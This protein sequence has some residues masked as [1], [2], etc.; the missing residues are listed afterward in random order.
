MKR[1][2]LFSLTVLFF[3]LMGYS[4][5]TWMDIGTYSVDNGPACLT[6]NPPGDFTHLTDVPAV[7]NSFYQAAVT[8][9]PSGAPI[10]THPINLVGS[11][12]T[13]TEIS[14]NSRE[15]CDFI[16]VSSHGACSR[17]N[18]GHC[19]WNDSKTDQQFWNSWNMHLGTSYNRWAYLY[20]CGVLTYTGFNKF[21]HDS[22]DP[23]WAQGWP[24]AFNGV[25]CILGFASETWE[26]NPTAT[27]LVNEFWTNWTGHSGV[28]YSIWL[29]HCYST[30][31]QLYNGGNYDISPAIITSRD[32]NGH[33]FWDDT[34]S[35]ATSARAVSWATGTTW[36]DYIH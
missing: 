36:V 9:Q 4:T 17:Y 20:S 22:T 27:N 1:I 31:D 6:C 3:A 19:L 23:N 12:V 32:A 2:S 34:Y 11:N 21:F 15:Y 33:Y 26:W 7:A 29:S 25:Q 14:N 28:S 16:F 13:V 24:Q 35:Q 10:P 8:N 30:Y 18:R 5:P